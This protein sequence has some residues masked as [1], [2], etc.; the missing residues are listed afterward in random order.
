[1]DTRER[2]DRVVNYIAEQFSNGWNSISKLDEI[3]EAGTLMGEEVYAVLRLAHKERIAVGEN[4]VVIDALVTMHSAWS[5]GF[6]NAS[7]DDFVNDDYDTV[8]S[9]IMAHA[10][11]DDFDE[12]G[13]EAAETTSP[14]LELRDL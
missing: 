1:M 9:A 11:P 12:A 13:D 6:E 8:K 7:A 5:D 14:T 3:D 2:I 10:F 4:D